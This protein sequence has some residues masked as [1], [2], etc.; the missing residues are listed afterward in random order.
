M[1][2]R[3][4]GSAANKTYLPSNAPVTIGSWESW[5]MVYNSTD[6]TTRLF[7]NGVLEQS[8]TT[9]NIGNM[10]STALLYFGYSQTWNGYL[11]GLLDEIRIYNRAITNDEVLQIYNAEKP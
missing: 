2:F 9:G 8:H 5:T 4:K 10:S 3:L 11:N 1:N 6:G 7:R